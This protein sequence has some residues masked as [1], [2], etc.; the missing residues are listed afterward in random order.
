[1]AGHSLRISDMT[2]AHLSFEAP[3]NNRDENLIRLRRYLLRLALDTNRLDV[4]LADACRAIHETT[5]SP[6]SFIE[7]DLIPGAAPGHVAVPVFSDGA[8]FGTLIIQQ[9]EKCTSSISSEDLREIAEL[10]GLGVLNARQAEASAELQSDSE[11]MLFHAP[12]AIFVISSENIVQ[13]ANRRV[14]DFVSSTLAEIVGH[15]LSEIFDETL[16]DWHTLAACARNNG[17]QEVELSGPAG[18]RLICLTPS[19][20]VNELSGR[21]LCVMR[22]ITA[23]RQA[24]LAI[25][26]TERNLLM[27]QAVEYLLHE[28]NNPLSALRANLEQA[29]KRASEAGRF[30]SASASDSVLQE[31][32]FYRLR[33]SID[34]MQQALTNA[35]TCSDRIRETMSVLRAAHLGSG[36]PIRAFVDPAYEI[37]LAL[38]GLEQEYPDSTVQITREES[39][40]A[41]VY[42]VPL[43]IAEAVAALVRNAIQSLAG[44]ADGRVQIVTTESETA[45][46]ITVQDNGPGVKKELSAQIFMPF[47]TTKPLGGNLG[48]GLTMVDDSL[49]RL[50]GSIRLLPAFDAPG[51]CFEIQIPK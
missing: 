42:T 10:L 18:R 24:H 11:D 13:M 43:T 1:M 45:L 19:F 46:R 47:F 38:S 29:R 26:R 51:A 4:I 32:T 3:R 33:H 50:G 2:D 5:G 6:C 20:V 12:D 40:S 7:G 30:V 23:E 37:T 25:R 41:K 49:R 35:G 21:I 31:D 8:A 9:P 36:R 22:D 39:I 27:G 44:R 15:T 14:L 28:V 48:L 17:V 34:K 16:V